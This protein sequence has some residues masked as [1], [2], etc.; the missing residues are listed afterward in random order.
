MRNELRRIPIRR[1]L[2]RKQMILGG[3]RSL[4][5]LAALSSSII[6]LTIA[7]GYSFIIGIMIASAIWS[8][9]IF[10]LR[11]IG[12]YDALMSSVFIKSLKYK[13]FYPAK[14]RYRKVD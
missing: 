2:N 9:E 3:E 10:L 6:G 14:G 4:V 7:L 11:L 12:K 5:L 8:I 1:S 13:E